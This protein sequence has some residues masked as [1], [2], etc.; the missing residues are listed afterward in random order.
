MAARCFRTGDLH[1]LCGGRSVSRWTGSQ[2]QNKEKA[3]DSSLP[4]RGRGVAT[5]S[6]IVPG[7]PCWRHRSLKPTIAL[8][9]TLVSTEFLWRYRPRSRR[10]GSDTFD[11]SQTSRA[12]LFNGVGVLMAATGLLYPV[13]AMVTM[14][15]SA[16]TIFIG[17]RQGRPQL[18]FDASLSVGRP[19][20]K[21]PQLS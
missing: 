12:F 15:T 16:T 20:L 10:S 19:I 18:I 14:A 3:Q 21:R 11:S 13:W 8:P 7:V 4:T 17:P 9:L 5:H 6:S 2:A 1:H